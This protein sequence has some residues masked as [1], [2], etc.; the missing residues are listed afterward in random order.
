ME[1]KESPK[2]ESVK[3]AGDIEPKT[4]SFFRKISVI[5]GRLFGII[6]F[7]L[8]VCLLPFVYSSTKSFLQEFS[9]VASAGKNYFWSGVITFIVI[10]LFIWEP[11]VIYN[12]GHELLEVVF[13]FFRPLVKVA[14]Y[15]VPIYTILLFILYALLSLVIKD[16]WFLRDA[17]FLFGFSIVLHLVFSARTVR[18]KKDDFL[19][20]NYLFG[21]SFIYIINIFIL[22]CGLSTVFKD[23]SF[24][25]FGK[26]A[27]EAA[28][29]IFHVVFRQLFLR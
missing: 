20:A 9:L 29:S 7:I 8:G 25:N 10:Y 3:P 14:P 23:F 22:A 15:L 21:F 17:L 24:V 26:S 18:S 4:G 19:K 5:S 2:K 11:A 6:K 28:G 27:F 1:K 12:K 13:S 16:A